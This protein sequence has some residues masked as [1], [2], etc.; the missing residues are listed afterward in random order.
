MFATVHPARCR[1]GQTNLEFSA[2]RAVVYPPLTPL[3]SRRRVFS[4]GAAMLVLTRK[5]KDRIKVS[6]LHGGSKIKVAIAREA[7]WQ[8]LRDRLDGA[9]AVAL[10]ALDDS[11][12]SG[13]DISLKPLSFTCDL[14]HI[15]DETE[16]EECLNS[17]HRIMHRQLPGDVCL[18]VHVSS[19]LRN[20][21]DSV[22][23]S[24]RMSCAAGHQTTLAVQC[25]VVPPE[26][27]A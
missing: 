1:D 18:L 27:Q 15:A 6:L 20:R 17:I 2:F 5:T 26:R 4:L 19:W 11:G 8:L 10:S 25:D 22:E 21:F 3:Q 16:F 9:V 7:E 12:M 14:S 13:G 24:H 23:W